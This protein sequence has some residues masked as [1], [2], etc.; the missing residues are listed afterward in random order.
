MSIWSL[1]VSFA[2]SAAPPPGVTTSAA[3]VGTPPART[4]APPRAPPARDGSRGRYRGRQYGERGADSRACLGAVERPAPTLRGEHDDRSSRRG[5]GGHELDVALRSQRRHHRTQRA[6]GGDHRVTP[7]SSPVNLPLLQASTGQRDEPRGVA[8]GGGSRPR[9]RPDASSLVGTR[10]IHR[11]GVGEEAQRSLRR[12]HGRHAPLGRRGYGVGCSTGRRRS[13]GRAAAAR[14]VP[15]HGS[16]RDGSLRDALHQ[17]E[18]TAVASDDGDHPAPR[19]WRGDHRGDAGCGGIVLSPRQPRL[20]HLLPRPAR[21]VASSHGNLARGC[22][23]GQHP[24]RR[25]PVRGGDVHEG[26]RSVPGHAR[27]DVVLGVRVGHGAALGG[28]IAGARGQRPRVHFAL[29]RHPRGAAFG[30]QTAARATRIACESIRGGREVRVGSSTV[31]RARSGARGGWRGFVF[32]FAWDR[33]VRVLTCLEH[34]QHAA[35][36]LA[37]HAPHLA[38]VRASLRFDT[39]P[40][41]TSGGCGFEPRCRS[42]QIFG[43]ALTELNALASRCESFSSL[44][45][46]P[47]WRGAVAAG[48]DARCE[49]NLLLGR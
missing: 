15:S 35:R 49:A 25:A 48:G 27:S 7:A 34:L 45:A 22:A 47:R 20:S 36:K 38:R 39:P 4:V 6:V 30:I 28:A 16:H 9:E 37:L 46:H 32:V 8:D 24:E 26:T 23:C 13:P 42:F 17:E 40:R 43:T 41:D 33:S 21:T 14:A 18:L 2:K 11:E 10:R 19:G 44:S 31:A 29:V 1:R 5:R 12:R 3:S